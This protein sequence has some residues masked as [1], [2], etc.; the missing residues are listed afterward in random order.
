MPPKKEKVAT[1][2]KDGTGLFHL[3][4]GDTYEGSYQANS[5]TKTM[6]RNGKK[7]IRLSKHKI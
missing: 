1:H 6:V 4:N 2:L 7:Y 5:K 3:P